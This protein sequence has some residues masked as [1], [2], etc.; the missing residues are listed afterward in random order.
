MVPNFFWPC[1]SKEIR[2]L[3]DLEGRE[4]TAVRE[5]AAVERDDLRVGARG[6]VSR[7]VFVVLIRF[8]GAS[9]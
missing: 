7:W 6:W 9:S 5:E 2:S 1:D 3:L 4:E 8:L